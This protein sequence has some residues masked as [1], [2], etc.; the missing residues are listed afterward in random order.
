MLF[1][2]LGVHRMGTFQQSGPYTQEHGDAHRCSATINVLQGI[3]YQVYR[4]SRSEPK[5]RAPVPGKLADVA[6]RPGTNV[7]L[8]TA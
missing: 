8:L 3:G 6:Q 4:P 7:K 5:G 1:V 2:H